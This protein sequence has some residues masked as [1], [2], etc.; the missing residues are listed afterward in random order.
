MVDSVEIHAEESTDPSLAQLQQ[1]QQEQ[2]NP[3]EAFEMP[4]KFKDKSPE[5]I[6]KSYMELQKKFS[7]GERG[8]E[9]SPTSSESEAGTNSDEDSE[10]SEETNDSTD[11][12]ETQGDV[13][14][15]AKF[16]TELQEKGELSEESYAELAKDFKVDKATVDKYIAGQRALSSS[17][18]AE[19]EAKVHEK[20]T[21][22]KEAYEKNI[23]WAGENFSTEEI[24]SF[25]KAI[26]GS[27]YEQRLAINDLQTRYKA[28]NGQPSLLEGKSTGNSIQG[29]KSMNELTKAQA[30]PRYSKYPDYRQ[31]VEAKLAISNI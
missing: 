3:T 14:V 20:F 10:G 8:A 9:E 30:D 24:D 16:S 23:A 11:T 1:E 19:F 6:A 13:D 7:S 28:A 29:F 17:E 31:E 12:Q 22:G 26:I 27:E 15:F 5:E 21:G 18:N 4:E 25:N 2:E